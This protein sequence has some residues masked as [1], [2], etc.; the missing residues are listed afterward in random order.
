MLGKIKE[1]SN[2]PGGVASYKEK[3]DKC[4]EKDYSGFNIDWF[5]KLEIITHTGLLK[6]LMLTFK[7]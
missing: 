5:V 6:I 7:Q 3:L 1:T 2:W 4:K